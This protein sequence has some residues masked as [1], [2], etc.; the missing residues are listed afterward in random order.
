M[1]EIP[2]E[3]YRHLMTLIEDGTLSWCVA[4]E[5]AAGTAFYLTNHPKDI[6]FRGIT[7]FAYPMEIGDQH[8]N[9]QGDLTS[10]TVTLSNVGRLP[11]S[12]LELGAWDQGKTT[13]LIC[14]V[15]DP[16]GV[17][18][19]I[20]LQYSITGAAANHDSVTLSLAQPNY[21]ERPFPGSR[22][23]RDQGFPGIV[24]NVA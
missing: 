8:D 6:Y 13:L 1:K 7:W 9:G 16:D 12:H 3:S 11:M 18:I 19:P 23:I 2:A 10:T 24:R 5:V 14:F 20:R 15:N 17:D 22:Y 4:I 21:L